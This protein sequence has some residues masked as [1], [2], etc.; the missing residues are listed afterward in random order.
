VGISQA[1]IA[2]GKI[3]GYSPERRH[4]PR[5][6]VPW[7]VVECVKVNGEKKTVFL[8][9][10]VNYSESG[11]CLNTMKLLREGQEVTIRCDVR[12]LAH[13]AVVK[14]SKEVT[15]FFYRTGLEFIDSHKVPHLADDAMPIR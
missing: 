12:E 11:L 3:R 7:N 4:S 9:A 5:Y 15:K 1:D 10:M 2:A 13:R 14:W 8:G 6:E